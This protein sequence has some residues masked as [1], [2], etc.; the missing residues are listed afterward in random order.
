MPVK[1][2]ACGFRSQL[3]TARKE[4]SIAVAYILALV[5]PAKI[6]DHHQGH[7]PTPP[8]AQ[9]SK[10]PLPTVFC[11]GTM[12]WLRKNLL[13]TV[14]G[15]TQK[16]LYFRRPLGKWGKMES[17]PNRKIG[18]RLKKTCLMLVC[19]CSFYSTRTQ[20]VSFILF[21]GLFKVEC[22]L[23]EANNFLGNYFPV[24]DVKLNATP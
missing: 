10:N 1:I 24:G 16:M 12:R 18:M 15:K 4:R 3:K 17:K 6:G 2:T 9:P 13:H 5:P 11:A 22:L 20:K 7:S 8:S 19:L 14:C 21:Y 23:L